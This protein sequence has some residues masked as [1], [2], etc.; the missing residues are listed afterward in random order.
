M[1]TLSPDLQLA[2]GPLLDNA[3]LS[4]PVRVPRGAP[5]LTFHRDGG[6]LDGAVQALVAVVFGLCDVVFAPGSSLVEQACRHSG[7]NIARLQT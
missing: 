5:T 3:L 7:Y 4:T 6:E 1:L 2:G